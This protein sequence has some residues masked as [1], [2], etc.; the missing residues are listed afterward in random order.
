MSQVASSLRSIHNP[1][2]CFRI[3]ADRLISSCG[4]VRFGL[5]F[6]EKFLVQ[7]LGD[8]T[9]IGLRLSVPPNSRASTKA[10]QPGTELYSLF[11]A[12]ASAV[13]S[14]QVRHWT[15]HRAGSRLTKLPCRISIGFNDWNRVL[16]KD[17][18]VIMMSISSNPKNEVSNYSS[19]FG[20]QLNASVAE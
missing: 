7:T 4:N 20:I 8:W 9:D 6:V 19:S 16:G 5:A 2:I 1:A 11:V 18:R 13:S 15:L 14:N 10:Y 3:A 17:H 12:F